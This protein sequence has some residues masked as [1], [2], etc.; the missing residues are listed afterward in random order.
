[1][2]E[3]KL[4]TRYLLDEPNGEGYTAAHYAAYRGN[5][6][7]IKVLEK[8]EAHFALTTNLKMTMLHLAA[9]GDKPSTLLYLHGRPLDINQQDSKMTTPLHWA[10]FSGSEKI[11]E[12]LLAQ[13]NIQVNPV[14]S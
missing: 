5:V 10:S 14:D 9:Q 3:I 8:Y 4:Y 13:P 2:A 11:V 6:S 7:V 12:Y 1:M